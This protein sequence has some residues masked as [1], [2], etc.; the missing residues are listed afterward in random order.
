MPIGKNSIK[1]AVNNGYSNVKTSAPDMENSE[2]IPTPV[3]V[4]EKIAPQTVKTPKI[5]STAKKTACKKNVKPVES[6]AQKVEEKPAK[7]TPAKKCVKVKKT[8]R[9]EIGGELPI[10]LL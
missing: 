2:V 7:K 5:S 10:Y 8:E 1:R 9:V 3:E 4:A 6:E